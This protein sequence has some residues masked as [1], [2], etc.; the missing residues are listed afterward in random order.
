MSVDLYDAMRINLIEH[1]AKILKN[2]LNPKNLSS[3]KM[4]LT[5]MSNIIRIF[6]RRND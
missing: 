5:F 2:T 4:I 3:K 6:A 1:Y